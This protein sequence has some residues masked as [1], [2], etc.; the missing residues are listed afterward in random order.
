MSKR[1]FEYYKQELKNFRS[2]GD[3]FAEDYPK[4]A[5]R[6][7][8][9][10]NSVADPHVERLIESVALIAARLQLKLDDDFSRIAEALLEEVTPHFSRPIPSHTIVTFRPEPGALM[11][12]HAIPQGTVLTPTALRS[13]P[14][15]AGLTCQFR[16]VYPVEL[17][18]L[19]LETASFMPV[20]NSSL[21]ARDRVSEGVITLSLR[22]TSDASLGDL[23]TTRL[24]LFVDGETEAANML[25]E[26]LMTQVVDGYVQDRD[27]PTDT[28]RRIGL[29]IEAV[30]FGVDE[31]LLRYDARSHVGYRLIQEFLVFPEKFRF[32]DIVAD[33]PIFRGTGSTADLMIV[34]GRFPKEDWAAELFG[35]VSAQNFV[36]GCT[37][38]INLF[39]VMAE[40]VRLDPGIDRYPVQA[41]LRRSRNL[42]VQ[43]IKEVTLVRRGDTVHRRRLAPMFGVPDPSAL[44]PGNGATDDLPRWTY[45]C[46]RGLAGEEDQHFLWL[47]D[48]TLSA[49]EAPG[50]IASVEAWCSNGDLPAMLPVGNPSGDFSYDGE[51][52]V[53]AIQCVRRPSSTVR[54]PHKEGVH[55]QLLSNLSLNYTSLVDAGGEGLRQ[56]LNA[57]NC[58]DPDLMPREHAEV[59]RMIEGLVDVRVGRAV[60]RMGP[61]T[62]RAFVQGVDVTITIDESAFAGSAYVFAAVL[63]RFLAIL[64]GANSFTRLHVVSN[65][66]EKEIGAW[67]CRAGVFPL[68]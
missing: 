68:I 61:G 21:I 30:G 6:L 67:P 46:E 15:M 34:T 18:P 33:E 52:P 9:S 29:R 24:R 43:A 22:H 56:L 44:G 55:W 53:E 50:A 8:L 7:Q 47:V 32:I 28:P 13:S 62:R 10:R 39:P 64:A 41:D 27:A 20:R 35:A 54:R 14:S 63:E 48:P 36:L 25:Y 58:F 4:I 1:L 23:E 31:G 19:D 49:L 66:R 65:Q 5:G 26:L 57:Y 42:E 45:E 12:P 17:L 40:P 2:Y 59:A 11:A 51:A 3:I 60:E 37:P 16:T 38:A